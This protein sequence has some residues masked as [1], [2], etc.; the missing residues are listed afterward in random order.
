MGE[1]SLAMRT[2]CYIIAMDR[3]L[4]M[5]DFAHPI[6]GTPDE[7]DFYEVVSGVYVKVF[8]KIC[9]AEIRKYSN[10]RAK[11]DIVFILDGEQIGGMTQSE[12]NGTTCYSLD[13]PSFEAAKTLNAYLYADRKLWTSHLLTNIWKPLPALDDAA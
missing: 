11:H 3:Y 9:E 2:D 10:L 7:F 12:K 1:L 8:T 5:R 6:L 4:G 13:A